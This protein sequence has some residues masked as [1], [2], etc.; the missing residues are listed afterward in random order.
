M[1]I[2]NTAQ[3]VKTILAKHPETRDSDN[4]LWLRVIEKVAWHNKRFGELQEMTVPYFLRNVHKL[5]LPNYETVSRARRKLQE[6]YPEL[7]GTAGAGKRRKRLETK[8]RE[9]ARFGNNV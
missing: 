6:N 2:I 7:R 3:I 8:Y 9:F 4:L 5:N 1:Y